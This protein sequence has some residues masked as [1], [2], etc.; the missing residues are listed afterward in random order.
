MGKLWVLVIA[1]LM[2]GVAP[3]SP[4]L[5]AEKAVY[6]LVGTNPGDSQGGYKG[7]VTL[8]TVGQLVKVTWALADGS[9][10]TGTG[11]SNGNTMAVGYPA[12]KAY[13]VCLYV[14]DPATE[15]VNGVWTMSGST[16]LGT[17]RWTLRH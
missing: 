1:V 5:A 6:D 7:T 10:V 11:L 12:G 16:T 8:E 13:G 3:L 4:A 14:R 17:E 15:E 2:A 9:K